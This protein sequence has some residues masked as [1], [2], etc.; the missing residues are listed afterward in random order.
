M[1]TG[2]GVGWIPAVINS[3]TEFKFIRESQH[4]IGLISVTSSLRDQ[5]MLK[6]EK[7]ENILSTGQ[8]LQVINQLTIL[9]FTNIF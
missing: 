4:V 7:T 6:G 1:I 5:L 2:I 3:A 8:L 9:I